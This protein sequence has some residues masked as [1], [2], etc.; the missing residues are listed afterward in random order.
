MAGRPGRH[1]SAKADCQCE[2]RHEVRAPWCAQHVPFCMPPAPELEHSCGRRSRDDVILAT[3]GHEG[4]WLART[5]HLNPV[6]HLQRR[7][8]KKLTVF[9]TGLVTKVDH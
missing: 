1:E 7:W 4:S 5:L 2:H 3:G 6:H 9:T 8:G